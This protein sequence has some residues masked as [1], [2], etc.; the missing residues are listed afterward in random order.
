MGCLKQEV[1]GL[2]EK[3]TKVDLTREELYIIYSA[4]NEICN[5]SEIPDFE[6]RIGFP[7]ETV[8]ALF[9]KM[10]HTYDL[11]KQQRKP[12]ASVEIDLTFDELSMINDTLNEICNGIEI[13]EFELR[14]GYQRERALAILKKIKDV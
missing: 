3:T 6:L 9:K 5:I 10:S 14:I 4:L 12:D 2:M 7:E 13:P 8:A 1:K 11:L